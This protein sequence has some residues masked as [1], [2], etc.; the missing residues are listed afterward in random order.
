VRRIINV[1]RSARRRVRTARDDF[2]AR[3]A[4]DGEASDANAHEGGG[5]DECGRSPVD[6]LR[7][8]E[9][10]YAIVARRRLREHG[11]ALRTR[12]LT[13]ATRLTANP[14]HGEVRLTAGAGCR[15]VGG[16]GGSAMLASHGGHGRSGTGC[17]VRGGPLAWARFGALAVRRWPEAWGRGWACRARGDS[18]AARRGRGS[19]AK[20]P[21][22]LRR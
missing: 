3:C 19:P 8:S 6:A 4:G 7:V 16:L 10:E 15:D 2:N 14:R 18:A 9:R 11:E 5:V 21:R 12:D 1:R 13:C 20:G 22:L 17:W